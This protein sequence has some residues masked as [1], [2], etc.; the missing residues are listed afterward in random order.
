MIGARAQLPREDAGLCLS[1]RG[2]LFRDPAAQREN[3]TWR[4]VTIWNEGI[5]P[6]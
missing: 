3:D 1:Q 2:A 6:Q 4:A 5:I